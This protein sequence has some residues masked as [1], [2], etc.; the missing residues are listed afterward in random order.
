MQRREVC[1]SGKT[2][3]LTHRPSK[4]ETDLPGFVG[5]ATM[6]LSALLLLCLAAGHARSSEPTI[7]ARP[8]AFATLIN[9][10]C[11]HCRDEAK[12]RAQ[13]LRDNDRVL[14]WVRGYSDGG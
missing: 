10:N 2:L 13:D 3:F 9:P 1:T 12:R 8:D 5:G 4:V 11:S 6:R 7:I 14:C